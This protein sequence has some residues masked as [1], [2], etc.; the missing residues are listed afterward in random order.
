MALSID[1]ILKL[2]TPQ[3]IGIVVVLSVVIMAVYWINGYQPKM[4]RITKKES[5]LA[6]LK[7]DMNN[8]QIIAS[9]YEKFKQEMAEKENE[10]Q[11]SLTKLPDQKEIPALLKSV[12]DMSQK[13]GLDVL[14]FRP[15]A[16]QPQQFFSKVPLEIK[17]VGSYPKIG[18]F[19]YYVGTL[20]RIISVDSFSLVTAQQK[21]KDEIQ[22]NATCVATTYRYVENAPPKPSGKPSGKPT[23]KK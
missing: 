5:K 17:F 16:E 6:E 13:A 20:S 8:K 23:R 9:N 22:L 12:S 10:L 1:T 4:K 3:K 21:K 11:R 2:P 14:L 19:F 7:R 18:L 15:Q